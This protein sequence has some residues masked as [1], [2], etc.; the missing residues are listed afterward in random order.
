MRISILSSWKNVSSRWTI[1]KVFLEES[2]D[3]FPF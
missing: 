1:E 2:V 3:V